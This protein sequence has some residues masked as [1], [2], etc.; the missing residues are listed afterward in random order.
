MQKARILTVHHLLLLQVCQRLPP[1]VHLSSVA[2]SLVEHY[3]MAPEK[4][5]N[6]GTEEEDRH[7]PLHSFYP[8]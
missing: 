2:D 3:H 4:A 5:Q 7:Q 1:L 8:D 6:G